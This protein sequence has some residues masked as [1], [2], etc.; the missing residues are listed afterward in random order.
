[1]NLLQ[2][3]LSLTFKITTLSNDFVA[4][5]ANGKT[6]AY[7]RQKLLKLYEEVHVFSN[8]N[9]SELNYTI[10]ANAWLDFS[11]SYVFTNRLGYEVGRIVRKGWASIWKAHYEIY[12][13]KQQPDLLVREENPWAKVFD[14][15]LGEIPILGVLSGYLFHPSYLVTR[16]DGM[17]VVQLKKESSFF[18]R[19]FSINKLAEFE[20]G[21]EERILLGLMM[22]I[23]LER[24]RG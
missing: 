11:A 2:F 12:D 17:P 4:Q 5:D 7:V 9:R 22:L 20:T 23:L 18:G 6:V 8:E 1:M 19:R 21:E 10:R 14:S 3:P 16:P 13:E 24:R 15:M